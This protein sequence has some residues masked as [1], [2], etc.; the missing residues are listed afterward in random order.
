MENW[1]QNGK[2]VFKKQY[3]ESQR[4]FFH[5]KYASE[6]K[7]THKQVDSLFATDNIFM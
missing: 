2:F 6:L 4:G 3:S 7:S 1:I 5:K